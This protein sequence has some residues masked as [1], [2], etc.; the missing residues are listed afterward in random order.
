MNTN[1]QFTDTPSQR[2]RRH[3]KDNSLFGREVDGLCRILQAQA[4]AL[5]SEY[6]SKLQ[7]MYVKDDCERMRKDY[8]QKLKEKASALFSEHKTAAISKQN[9][10]IKDFEEVTEKM[11]P[12]SLQRDRETTRNMALSTKE[13]QSKVDHYLKTGQDQSTGAPYEADSLDILTAQLRGR[14]QHKE[15][16]S[17]RLYD[18]EQHHSHEPWRNNEHFDELSEAVENIDLVKAHF[19]AGKVYLNPSHGKAEFTEIDKLFPALR[20]T[21]KLARDTR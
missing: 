13:L 4:E 21:D 6:E 7:K 8:I 11:R 18:N 17:I 20:I 10:Y 19:E 2:Q 15:A 14:G 1:Y 12:D 3:Q 9:E 16:D 5:S